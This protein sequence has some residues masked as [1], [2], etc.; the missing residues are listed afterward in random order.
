MPGNIKS[1]AEIIQEVK[2]GKK[3]FGFTPQAAETVIP[4]IVR[5]I[6]K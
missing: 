4:V 1:E 5:E 2:Q 3:A 6:Q